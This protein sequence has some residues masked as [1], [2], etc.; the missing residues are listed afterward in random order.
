MLSCVALRC[1]DPKPSMLL[2]PAPDWA[3]P[4]GL[5]VMAPARRGVKLKASLMICGSVTSKLPLMVVLAKQ[6]RLLCQG[7]PAGAASNLYRCASEASQQVKRKQSTHAEMITEL[8]L[9]T[10]FAKKEGSEESLLSWRGV[11]PNPSKLV[12]RR[13]LRGVRAG[14]QLSDHGVIGAEIR[15]PHA[16]QGARHPVV[17]EHLLKDATP[18]LPRGSSIQ[19]LALVHALMLQLFQQASLAHA[20]LAL[21][22]NDA[23]LLVAHQPGQPLCHLQHRQESTSKLGAADCQGFDTV[24]R[25]PRLGYY[26][27]NHSSNAENTS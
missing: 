12:R 21:H 20:R 8:D 6:G 23:A 13:T 17:V 27:V 1:K 3:G 9:L 16:V 2:L 14:A 18:R 7:I 25:K 15:V 5:M 4:P 19:G 10:R 22:H 11:P 24:Y 26:F